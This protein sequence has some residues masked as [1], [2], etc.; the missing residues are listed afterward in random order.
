LGSPQKNRRAG[1]RAFALHPAWGYVLACLLA[2]PAAQHWRAG[3]KTE[4]MTESS[5]PTLSPLESVERIELERTRGSAGPIRIS[6]SGRHFILSFVVPVRAGS[7]YTASIEKSNG[8]KVA[9]PSPILLNEDG[10]F[11]LVCDRD[12]FSAGNYR[13]T[14]MEVPARD[15]GQVLPFLVL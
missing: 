5:S 8:E 7:S 2:I 4:P 12:A 15:G 10:Y 6:T 1:W 13:L 14:V 9:G 11:Y 3:R